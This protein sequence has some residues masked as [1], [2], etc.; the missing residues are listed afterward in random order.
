MVK[1]SD[2]SAGNNQYYVKITKTVT[3][4]GCPTEVWISDARPATGNAGMNK[5]FT[6]IGVTCGPD[7]IVEKGKP[8]A[9]LTKASAVAICQSDA[10]TGKTFQVKADS[11]GAISK[12]TWHYA[13]VTAISGNTVT[14]GAVT[15][16]KSCNNI[17]A[18]TTGCDF[19]TKTEGGMTAAGEW[20][21]WVKVERT[22]SSDVYIDSI[23]FV[24]RP[25]PS[26]L[27]NE[28][29]LAVKLRKQTGNAEVTDYLVCNPTAVKLQLEPAAALTAL[30]AADKLSGEA[31]PTDATKYAWYKMWTTPAT[32]G[33][34]TETY[35][36]SAAE[37]ATQA[38]TTAGAPTGADIENKYELRETYQRTFVRS[39]GLATYN[40]TCPAMASGDTLK[41]T[42]PVSVYASRTAAGSLKD[43]AGKSDTSICTDAAAGKDVKLVFTPQATGNNA[44]PAAAVTVWEFQTDGGAWQTWSTVTAGTAQAAANTLTVSLDDD[45][46]KPLPAANVLKTYTFRVK[47]KNG[48]ACDEA[49]V[50]KYDLKLY[51]KLTAGTLGDIDAVCATSTGFTVS[52]TASG[53]DPATANVKFSIYDTDPSTGTPTA[54]ATATKAGAGGSATQTL[55]VTPAP[56]AE[57]TYYV[58]YEIAPV[59]GSPCGTVYSAVKE[60]KVYPSPSIKYS[61]SISGNQCFI[62]NA[63]LTFTPIA[64]TN[65][66]GF[67]IYAFNTSKS[68]ADLKAEIIAGT[69]KPV[70]GTTAFTKTATSATVT[71]TAAG[72]PQAMFSGTTHYYFVAKS[73][74]YATDKNATCA[75]AIDH[76]TV[77]AVNP[78]VKPVITWATGLTDLGDIDRG[79]K[80]VINMTGGNREGSATVE[81]T[82]LY[83]A[84]AS[85][86]DPT[87][88]DLTKK[89]T[90][91]SGF[92]N[93]YDYPFPADLTPGVYYYWVEVSGTPCDNAVSDPIKANVT[94]S[95]KLNL[96][97]DADVCTTGDIELQ[98]YVDGDNADGVNASTVKYYYAT[99]DAGKGTAGWTE[100]NP[101]AP[102]T[103]STV[104]IGSDKPFKLTWKNHGLGASADAARYFKM[105]YTTT[106]GTDME[107]EPAYK[108]TAHPQPEL[109]T[110]DVFDNM[111]NAVCEGTDF[112]VAVKAG[113]VSPAKGTAGITWE[114]KFTQTDTAAATFGTWASKGTDAY[115]GVKRTQDSGWYRLRVKGHDACQ[116]VLSNPSLLIVNHK[117]THGALTVAGNPACFGAEVTVTL[118]GYTDSIVDYEYNV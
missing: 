94:K 62:E 26:S 37:A 25:N 68:D 97:G 34:T 32:A 71:Y 65:T 106:G 27:S 101:A 54:L 102:P 69:A 21:I 115:A 10:N 87:K 12:A 74:I 75:M 13:P 66:E 99:T 15:V 50:Q 59:S 116:P 28:S 36:F 45:K 108:V 24:I 117:P 105:V 89:A 35:S 110:L 41:K 92:T 16:G 9:A 6:V 86:T 8:T 23:H 85:T 7:Q 113:V 31:N 22:G 3:A 11:R 33:P 18:N 114:L 60:V 104:T 49:T 5:A 95:D 72:T 112:S 88:P 29:D 80:H 103:G 111:P 1:A 109:S 42:F 70:N 52:A 61:G 44:T 39:A 73:G 55:T 91:R 81:A 19:N 30:P 17:A 47:V 38:V 2:I 58:R 93:G 100:L 98:V 20:R 84:P 53:F 40:I 78:L 4:D 77:T 76:T 79:Q 63:S 90:A 67:D 43:A 56:S 14:L 48:A 46:L 83:Y 96:E 118:S 64:Q 51:G 57:K 82:T 107:T